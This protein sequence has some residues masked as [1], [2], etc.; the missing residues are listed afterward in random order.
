[1]QDGAKF[2]D[3]AAARYA[4]RKVMDPAA[5]AATLERVRAHLAPTDRVLEAGCG[6][7]TTALM[8]APGVAH[9]T[10]TD[11]AGAMIGIAQEKAA[12]AGAANVAFLRAGLDD[13]ALAGG[14]FDA[15]LAFNL[16]HLIPDTEGAVRRLAGLVRPGGKVIVK[17]PCLG[18]R[19][20]WLRPVVWVLRQFGRAPAVRF[21]KVAE[22]EAMFP[23][24]GLSIVERG[25]YP[26]SL[27]SRFVVA[28]RD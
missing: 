6:T 16:L 20:G 21:L 14:A 19:K 9:L 13:P 25:D 5:Y 3:R 22:M 23:A 18:E 11:I 7:G 2:W 12:R 4:R 26:A 27:P 1:M 24:A 8:L 17:T 10:G 15:V 28:V